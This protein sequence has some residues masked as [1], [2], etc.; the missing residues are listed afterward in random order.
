MI[1]LTQTQL[2]VLRFIEAYIMKRGGVSPSM[3]EIITFLG[4]GS[5]SSAQS[6]LISLEERGRIRRMRNRARAIEVVKP[7]LAPSI[8]GVPL[9]FIPVHGLGCTQ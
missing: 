4:R 1:G 6:I 2:S 9:R 8:N 3:D 7:S 5:K